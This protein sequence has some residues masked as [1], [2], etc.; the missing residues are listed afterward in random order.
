VALPT[1][2]ELTPTPKHTEVPATAPAHAG[3]SLPTTQAPLV[4]VEIVAPESANL[5]QPLTQEIVVRNLGKSAVHQVRV[6]QELPAGVRYLGGEPRAET[7][8][9]RL[10]WRVGTIEATSEK[11]ITVKLQPSTEG[12]LNTKSTVSF[13]TTCAAVTRLTRPKLTVAITG[14]ASALVG[15][16]AAFQIKLTNAGT[17]PIE[18]LLL[19]DKLPAGL[20]HPQGEMLEAEI[21]G[22]APG[23]ARI[24]TLKTTCAK[25]GN[26]VHEIQAFADGAAADIQPTGG[27]RNPDLESVARTEIKIVEPGLQVKLGGPKTCLIKCEGVLL[28]DVT[29][30]GTASAKNITITTRVPDGMEFVAMSDEG[31]FDP[32]T[33]T[34]TWGFTTLEPAAN[35]VLTLKVRGTALGDV[36][37]AA[38]ARADGGLNAKSE[39]PVHIDGVPA[40]GLEIVNVDDPAQV[41]A[42]ATYE[43]RVVNR[44]TCPCTGIQ[45]VAIMPEGMELREA[46]APASYKL[47]GQQVQFAPYPKLAT[48]ADLVYKIKCR[49]KVPGDVR[50]R[51]QLT[52]DQLQQPV[53]KEESSRFYKP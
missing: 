13:A 5:A 46:A 38:L 26:Y 36:G 16:T 15:E 17:G 10:A 47:Q 44:G 4:T 24:V 41:G 19:R 52:C 23:E 22:L 35:R 34:A 40:L 12:E 50:F 39:L 37:F 21:A 30:P 53:L 2:N 27:V 25:V 8:N 14:P 31:R 45:I 7:T 18:K 33:K 51:V 28:I 3:G 1:N 6:E 48:K 29:N 11:R 9:D 20:Q 43:V 42:D 49:S 32:A